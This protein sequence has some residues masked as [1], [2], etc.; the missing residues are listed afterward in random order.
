MAARIGR[1]SAATKQLAKRCDS[2]AR[3]YVIGFRGR[4]RLILILPVCLFVGFLK[5]VLLSRLC[6]GLRAALSA[7]TKTKT[8]TALAM[9]RAA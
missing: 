7:A 8:T 4:S 9:D 1:C 5:L 2:L 6:A 3:S